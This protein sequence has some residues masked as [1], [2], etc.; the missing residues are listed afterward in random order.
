VRRLDIT[1]TFLVHRFCH[2]D[3]GVAKFLRNID[4]Y[5]SHTV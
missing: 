3:E 4:S 2:P 1:V 5:K